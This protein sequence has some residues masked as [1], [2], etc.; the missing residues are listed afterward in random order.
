MTRAQL[1]SMYRR[2]ERARSRAARRLWSLTSTLK[3][4]LRDKILS[5]AYQAMCAGTAAG[6]IASDLA[7][8]R[9]DV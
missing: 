4:P 2:E 9:V 1:E 3:K 7:A 6:L 5:T 8:D